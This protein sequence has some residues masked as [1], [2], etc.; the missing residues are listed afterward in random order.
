MAWF[1]SSPFYSLLLVPLTLGLESVFGLWVWPQK[2]LHPIA[3]LGRMIRRLDQRFNNPQSSLFTQ[4]HNGVLIT[5][6]VVG[7]VFLLGIG[8]QLVV[9]QLSFGWILY[10]LAA[11]PFFAQASLHHYVKA[12]ADALKTGGLAEGRLAVG[13][14]VG[15]ETKNLDEAGIARAAIE[16]CA[17]SFCDAVVAPAFWFALLGLPGLFAYKAINTLDSM[18]GYRNTRYEYFGKAAARLD[19]IVNYIP[20]RLSAIFLLIAALSDKRFS[21]SRGYKILRRDSGLHASP[22]AGWPEAAVAGIL[23]LRL[24]GPRTYDARSGKTE[25]VE[26][27]GSEGADATRTDIKNMLNLYRAACGIHILFWA[28]IA[29]SL[30]SLSS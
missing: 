1:S 21:A 11:L 19:D 26:W 13:H 4:F 25:A 23:N 14:I 18:I 24:G 20:A 22:N 29:L 7:G 17:E 27:I 28:I 8:M 12:T 2:L 30:Y 3:V 15:R 9:A 16:S 5:L 6:F 10:S